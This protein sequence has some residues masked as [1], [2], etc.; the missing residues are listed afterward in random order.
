MIRPLI[1]LSAL[2]GILPAAVQSQH[3]AAEHERLRASIDSFVSQRAADD[4]FSGAVL[5]ARGDTIVYRRGVGKASHETGAPMTPD[6]SLTIA[7]MTKLFTQIAIRQLAQAGRLALADTVGKFLPRYP[8]P[9]VRSKVTIEQLL[10]HRSGIGNFWNE[11]YAARRKDVRTVSDYLQL[12]QDDSLLFEPGTKQQYSNGGYVVLGA[13]I[14]AVTG[15][16]YHE[17]LADHVFRPSGMSQTTPYDLR[18]SPANAAMGYTR[19]SESGRRSEGPRR[20]NTASKP[21]LSGPAG[22]HYSSVDDLHKLAKAL[23]AHRLLDSTH[24]AALLGPRYAGGADFRAAGGGPGVNAELSLYPSG[25]VVVVL[26]NYDP[27]SATQVAQ[28]IQSLITSAPLANA[29]DR[30]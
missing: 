16:S 10:H 26:S 14:E 23:T 22:D 12:F 6:A 21:G 11:R 24:T 17:Y 1:A 20:P 4:A 19:M 15:Q 27:P 13:I 7:S 3:V 18:A 29:R 8:N 30:R 9:I 5:V 2:I 28:F 25:Y